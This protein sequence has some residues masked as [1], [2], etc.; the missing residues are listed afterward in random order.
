[1]F[2]FMEEDCPILGSESFQFNSFVFPPAV[3]LKAE[4]NIVAD[5]QIECS[6]FIESKKE[7]TPK[8]ASLKF[9]EQDKFSM[10]LQT[11]LCSFPKISA[12]M[13]DVITLSEYHL[14]LQMKERATDQIQFNFL[15][16][17]ASKCR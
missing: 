14:R 8:L 2:E 10:S 7:D 17:R 13:N 9:S 12:M 6:L 16:L 1:M 5:H 11:L 15:Q 3:N 4:F